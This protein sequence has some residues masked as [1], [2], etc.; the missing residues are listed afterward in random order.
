MR[1]FSIFLFALIAAGFGTSVWRAL[2][3]YAPAP[4]VCM[5]DTEKVNILSLQTKEAGTSKHAKSNAAVKLHAQAKSSK[6]AAGAG[7]GSGETRNAKTQTPSPAPKPT[8]APGV[9]AGTNKHGTERY[10]SETTAAHF[11]LANADLATEMREPLVTGT[12]R[13]LARLGC[14]AGVATGVWDRKTQAAAS[15]F[16]SRAHLTTAVEPSQELLETLRGYDEPLCKLPIP[17]CKTG[18]SNN[19]LAPAA[20]AETAPQKHDET[21]SYLPPW[22][23]P[24]ANENDEAT[25]AAAFAKNSA[26]SKEKYVKRGSTTAR[27]LRDETPR[28]YSRR[29]DWAPEGWPRTAN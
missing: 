20:I 19:C 7:G 14:F 27:N 4:S 6:P 8:I 29:R 26:A 22:M 23:K 9:V 5:S 3:S 11:D 17:D 2:A 12:Q 28:E 25:A 21:R 13:E 16:A 1:R 10:G 18:G 24:E 15:T